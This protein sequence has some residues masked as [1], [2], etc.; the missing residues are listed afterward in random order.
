MGIDINLIVQIKNKNG[1]YTIEEKV[2]NA[3]S[4]VT[5][6]ILANIR[7]YTSSYIKMPRGLP[8]DFE[9]EDYYTSLVNSN[10]KQWLG[11]FSYSYFTLL[12]LL[13]TNVSF[14]HTYLYE[15]VEQLLELKKK[16]KVSLDSIRVVFG[17]D[18]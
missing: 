1:W 5:F 2:K 10:E 16:Y 7:N 13:E 14:E 9:H 4:Y 17:F 6:G 8:E 11:A 15:W 3:R 12:E 18:N